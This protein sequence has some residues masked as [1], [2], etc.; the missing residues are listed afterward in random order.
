M[1]SAIV[2]VVFMLA[3]VMLV[4]WLGGG[5]KWA[6]RTMLGL[7]VL[8]L[9][10][11]GGVFGYVLW[12]EKTAEHQRQRI[13]ECAVAKIATAQCETA[14]AGVNAPPGSLIC[15]LYRLNENDAPEQEAAALAA[16]EQACRAE[17]NP[18]EEPLH[19]QVSEYRQKHG[20]KPPESLLDQVIREGNCAD[21]VRQRYPGAYNDLDDA[22]LV[23][24]VLAKYPK[25]CEANSGDPPGWEPVIEGIR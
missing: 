25:Y 16:A 6:F 11:A 8:G 24:K 15:P 2:A 4:S 1:V 13:H 5:R 20:I 10:G 22:T 7:L 14:P 17:M 9:L 21:K 18:E 19:Q 12:T 23:K 3:V